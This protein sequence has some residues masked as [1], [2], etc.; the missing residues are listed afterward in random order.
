MRPPPLA[1][2][3]T[4]SLQS[5][6]L[7]P[8]AARTDK[9][10]YSLKCACLPAGVINVNDL[11][12]VLGDYGKTSG[13]DSTDSNGDVR[14]V[15]RI[16]NSFSA[17]FLPHLQLPLLQ[18]V[19]N[20]SDLL[21]LLANY[22]STCDATGSGAGRELNTC[23]PKNVDGRD[24][25]CCWDRHIARGGDTDEAWS[26]RLYEAMICDPDTGDGPASIA[27]MLSGIDNIGKDVADLL[28]TAVC[29]SGPV[30][31]CACDDT[32]RCDAPEDIE[33]ITVSGAG[34]PAWNGVYRKG[35]SAEHPA[36]GFV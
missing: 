21:T 14:R 9:A 18:G 26:T 1:T 6:A 33:T 35:I 27:P 11:L 28:C 24:M 17:S 16:L 32:V 12:A 15:S 23:I 2:R 13:I 8:G 20:V 10:Q 34:S 22:G 3:H 5:G 31:L 7:R 30:P 19:I 25:I 4:R 29:G 36:D